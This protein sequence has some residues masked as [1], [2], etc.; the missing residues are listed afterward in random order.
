M[1]LPNVVRIDL[2]PQNTLLDYM[3]PAVETT[4]GP[5]DDRSKKEFVYSKDDKRCIRIV[6]TWFREHKRFVNSIEAKE[7]F[8][9]DGDEF[10]TLVRK[11]DRDKIFRIAK[12]DSM[13]N[14]FAELFHPLQRADELAREFDEEDERLNEE[15]GHEVNEENISKHRKLQNVF[16]EFLKND[17]KGYPSET[18]RIQGEEG[19]KVSLWVTR[20]T[21]EKPI[22]LI[23]FAES[24]DIKV[25]GLAAAILN[26]Y[27]NSY[28]SENCPAFLVCPSSGNSAE[29]FEIL[30][31]SGNGYESM[32][33]QDFPTYKD[34]IEKFTKA[35]ASGGKGVDDI[36]PVREYHQTL[37]LFLSEK[38]GY[39]EH[40][41]IGEGSRQESGN[42]FSDIVLKD[43]ES[44]REL[45]V[46]ETNVTKKGELYVRGKIKLVQK[47]VRLGV[48]LY[49]LTP[50]VLD[51]DDDFGILRLTEK[52]DLE[53][54][55][56]EEFPT[57]K[58][59]KQKAPDKKVTLFKFRGG[60]DI[61]GSQ[62]CDKIIDLV[63]DSNIGLYAEDVTESYANLRL[64]GLKK[65]DNVAVQIHKYGEYENQ[66]ALA[67]VG[68]MKGVKVSE[69]KLNDF[70]DKGKITGLSGYKKNIPGEKAWLNGNLPKKGTR[71]KTTV[72]VIQGEIVT[73]PGQLNALGDILNLGVENIEKSPP[74]GPGTEDV[75]AA[76][77]GL[78]DSSTA[79]DSLG[80]KP[81]VE[82]VADFLTH[83]NT[84]PP[85]VLS[86]EGEWGSGKSSF[87]WQL[88]N[89][90]GDI[91]KKRTEKSLIVEFDP[92]R[93]D[94]DE[95]LWAAF[96][97]E[98]SRQLSQGFNFWEKIR[99][100]ITLKNSRFDWSEGWVDVLKQGVLAF[101]WILATSV[102]CWGLWSGVKIGNNNV[103]IP[104]VFGSIIVVLVSVWGAFGKVRDFIGNPLD[105]DLRKYMKMPDYDRHVS[106]IEKFHKDFEKII[107]AYAGNERVFVFIDDLDRCAIPMAAELME[108]I[109]KMISDD[110]NLVFVMGM[111]REK[112][113]A[114]LAVKHEKLL[115]YLS[116]KM[117]QIDG[118]GVESKGSKTDKNEESRLRGIRYG[119]SF[120]EKFIQIPF[121]LPRPNEDA[122]KELLYSLP[123]RA[124]EETE[125]GP[126]V[127]DSIADADQ[128]ASVKTIESDEGNDEGSTPTD[129]D[130]V[131]IEATAEYEDEERQIEEI[132][133]DNEKFREMAMMIAPALGNNPR[134]VKQFVNLLRLRFR[135]AVKTGL[136]KR[137]GGH[138]EI[139]FEQL[140]KFVGIGLGWPLLMREIEQEP[141]LLYYLAGKAEKNNDIKDDPLYDRWVKD[142]KLTKLLKVNVNKGEDG[143]YSLKDVNVKILLDVSPGVESSELSG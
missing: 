101:V 26:Q 110:P 99:A 96:V 42:Y 20:L 120:L 77:H 142:S 63:G 85:L 86:V 73:V 70:I 136:L 31:V 81:Y 74:K 114:G 10:E 97:L 113:A 43:P 72:Y 23:D 51:S 126:A 46:I 118:K 57:Y 117:E 75:G 91:Y 41:V 115:P 6:A 29:P 90:I 100:N 39:P 137:D 55:Y 15:R 67:V 61:E 133:G 89:K 7:A 109:N 83:Q 18:I 122:I 79:D 11:L 28:H 33:I 60:V 8:G 103:I 59:L 30:E 40:S 16:I 134:R 127:S 35:G 27:R 135:I 22:A 69:P 58:E 50:E 2:R 52:G 121:F 125:N 116:G 4:K 88:K 54:I 139:T 138:G 124:I 65:T 87:M 82:A 3:N 131:D 19:K 56:L 53:E 36:N 49:V 102:I 130:G 106:L 129:P 141:N 80:F 21:D 112:V 71:E 84:K 48:L 32:L 9:V 128:V 38:K 64:T 132:E 78:S 92:W 62:I 94:K 111:D 17:K 37:M 140:G 98:F 95:A 66:I 13:G 76:E 12:R 104:E 34:L 14:G 108:S 93:H 45:A 119:Y 24:N 143:A 107:K 123:G 68:P 25:I 105:V 5:A 44:E 1:K 47:A